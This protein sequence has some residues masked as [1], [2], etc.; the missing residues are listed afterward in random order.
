VE[1][2]QCFRWQEYAPY[3]IHLHTFDSYVYMYICIQGGS[4]R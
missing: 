2:T 4:G 3:H 1:K